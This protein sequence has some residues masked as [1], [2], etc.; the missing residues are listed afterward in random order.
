[1]ASSIASPVPRSHTASRS[2]RKDVV[3]LQSQEDGRGT[4]LPQYEK[5]QSVPF[6][7]TLQEEKDKPGQFQLVVNVDPQHQHAGG[8]DRLKAS[9]SKK[10]VANLQQAP[11]LGYDVSQLYQTQKSSPPST[12]QAERQEWSEL[13]AI[14]PEF[15]EKVVPD[16]KVTFSRSD[17]TASTQSRKL[18]DI[19]A[20][21]KKSGK[22]FVV[23]LL[24]GSNADTNEVR[25]VHLGR[26]SVNQL[27]T[28][29]ELDSTAPPVEL[30]TGKTNNPIPTD[31]SSEVFEIGTSGEPGV[32]KAP[33]PAPTSAV[34]SIPQ[35]LNQTSNEAS[36]RISLQEDSFSDAETLLSDVRSIAD[37]MEDHADV[38]PISSDCSVLP[39]RSSSVLSIVKTPT[40]GLSVVGP[41]RRV[42]KGNRVRTKGKMLRGD[43]N[44]TGARKSF[45]GRSPQ[46]SI[47]ESVVSDRLRNAAAALSLTHVPRSNPSSEES[48]DD[49]SSKKRNN[50][51]RRTRLDK[52]DLANRKVR[53][54]SS[55]PDSV[56]TVQP[57]T[58]P[59]LETN[60]PPSKSANAS[61][62][63][64]R[65]RSPRTGRVH[66][67]TR[68]DTSVSPGHARVIDPV[69]ASPVWSE[70]GSTDADELREAL[71]EAF[72][73]VAD[74][75][76]S[77]LDRTRRSIPSIKEPVNDA[78]VGMRPLSPG[79]E[80][81]SAPTTS[82]N[83]V[84][85]FWGLALGAV[86]DKVV[87]GLQHLRDTYGS[88]P[89][90]P[91]NHVRVRW[92]CSCGEDLY[93]DFI[94]RRPGA[95]RWL[96][97][98]LNR[99]RAHTP[100]SSHSRSSTATSMSSVFDNASR[101]STLATPSSTYGGSSSWGKS[102]N[103]SKYSPTRVKSN[104]PFSVSI[105][106]PVEDSW[107]LTCANEGK[108]TPKVVHLDVNTQRIRSDKDLA[109]VLRE[110]YEHLNRRW[111]KWTRLRG[112]TTIEFVHFEVHRNRFADI[113]ATPSMPPTTSSVSDKSPSQHPYTFETVDLMPP[114]G[115]HYLLHLFKHP[116]DYDGELIA[117][118]RAPKRR[119]RLEFGMG[120]G[121][122]L[123]EGFLAQKVWA[124]LIAGFGVGSAVFGILWTIKKDDVQGAFGVA[125]WIVTLAA[126]VLG[127]LQAWLE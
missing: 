101:A 1:M 5:T 83:R 84:A 63:A 95:A 10:L 77:S 107:L 28:L 15:L 3:N 99:P 43:L 108:F 6:T 45:I 87:E 96:E 46:G 80:I 12:P 27:P 109:M 57:K 59:R 86:L 93:D 103:S 34:S 37:Q 41:V 75:L 39:T 70:V 85:L 68:D 113:R 81:R 30:D 49:A 7:L 31:V 53:R 40:R 104:N 29:S 66:T 55:L 54:Q 78:E 48:S 116:E 9:P 94:E 33:R 124:V 18:A 98:Y 25:E 24:K 110:H 118:L 14:P 16:W 123:V 60:L 105:H 127:A 13:D 17:S 73:T 72:G 119:E 19:K 52:P 74:D 58:L 42:E 111:L 64:M 32:E 106:R 76:E 122:N 51:D 102:N 91:A 126:L 11:S 90:V 36:R 56:P 92:T 69:E 23:R 62:T 67:R 65:K 112:L 120:W 38:E 117:Y 82:G 47:S 79:L 100:T 44:R 114:V 125:G 115:S 22:G 35:W 97:G 21:I 4:P 8:G 20:R 88:E 89:P 2:M 61:P 26:N 71:E 50:Q 121:I